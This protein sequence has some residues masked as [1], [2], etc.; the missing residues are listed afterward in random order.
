MPQ[1]DRAIWLAAR[2]YLDVR[3]N[4][5]HTLHAYWIAR[6]LLTFHAEAREDIV[7]PAM[8][9]HDVGA[10]DIL[11]NNAAIYAG[12]ARKPFTEI[13]EADWDR[14]MAVNVKGTWLASKIIAPNTTASSAAR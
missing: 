13:E 4:D 10:I 3:N 9:L 2:P 8:L 12:I 1:R 6:A 14:I 7:L 5:E 11:V